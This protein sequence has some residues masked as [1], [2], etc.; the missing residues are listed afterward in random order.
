MNRKMITYLLGRVLM[1]E[2]FLMI[3][4]VAV[5]AI[6]LERATL[7]FIIP[8]LI[9]VLAGL[10]FGIKKPE[11]T[12]IYVR[13]GFFIVAAAW[14]FMSLVGA[15]PFYISSFEFF[16]GVSQFS[17]IWD[18]IFEIIS[19]FTTT[20]AS[21]CP[22]P[23]ILPKCILFWRS[24]SHWVGGMGVLVFVLAIIP[25]SD[26]MH[27]MKAEVPG[28]VVGKL[29]PKMRQTARILYAVYTVMTL[30]LIV[31]LC[32]GKMP[33]F[34]AIC[35]SFGTAGTG[36]F[37]VRTEGIGYY[38]SAYI[39]VVLS[40]FMILFGINFNLFY[41][42][43]IKRTRE[44][45]RSEELRCYLLVVGAAT[46]AVALN[47]YSIYQNAGISLRHAFFQ[48]SS[49]ITTTG[50]STVDFALW[51]SLSQSI[52]VILMM[53]GACAGSTG[54]GLKVSRV[55]LL[56]KAF[57]QE[58]KHL[59]HPR[60]VTTVR[61]EGSPV[62]NSV[63]RSTLAYFVIYV[64]IVVLSTLMISLD[65]FDLTTN[66]TAELSCLNNIGPG[67]GRVGPM[68]NFSGFSPLSKVIL[69]LNMLL[70][71]L[72]IFP[73]IVFFSPGSWKKN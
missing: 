42:I 6:Y 52:I 51:P 60:S 50:Y 13:E 23:G 27:L 2:F 71:R 39:D 63:V 49:I 5:G 53:V 19:G 33:L 24:F 29:V 73:I 72:E 9:L 55:L 31:F 57:V 56:L 15:L 36:G 11:N 41:L 64:F 65:G 43:L 10:T 20:G 3:P 1:A 44:A 70:G 18:C 40:I 54:G 62:E 61:L 12:A 22:D 59:L 68:E 14:I 37:S 28:P 30:V 8:M 47:I 46:F 21:I 67:L 4:S 66:L 16:G 32:A 25:M 58:M 26:S 48:V 38:N 45:L 34:E 17:C 35:H 7:S 69:S